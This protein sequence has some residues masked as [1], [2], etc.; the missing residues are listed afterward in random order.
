M[1][2]LPF[3][4][5]LLLVGVSCAQPCLADSVAAKDFAFGL[6]LTPDK[7]EPIHAFTLPESVLRAAVDPELGDLCVF[8]AHGAER[9]LALHIPRDTAT[10]VEELALAHFPLQA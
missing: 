7:H 4:L 3:A 8:D 2:T 6:A 10:Q 1:R 9:P 5:S